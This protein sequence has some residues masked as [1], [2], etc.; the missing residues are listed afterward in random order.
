MLASN[1]NGI[2][3]VGEIIGNYYFSPGEILPHRRKIKWLNTDIRRE[4]MSK[5]LKNSSGS[6]GTC[7]NITKYASE[8]EAL[9]AGSDLHE[10]GSETITAKYLSTDKFLERSLHRLL[11]NNLLSEGILSKTIFHEKSTKVD[12][13]RKWV[14][15]DMVG[16]RF[17]EFQDSATRT[18]LKAAD[19][20]QYL[21]I[22]SYELKRILC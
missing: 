14:H 12:Q 16:V 10:T 4:D 19:T 2:Y 22:Y 18:L 15:P 11:A 20:K 9:I 1:G 17:N 7:C 3:K 8:I 21:D 5:T 13:A 6:I